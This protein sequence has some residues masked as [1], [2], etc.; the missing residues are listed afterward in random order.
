MRHAEEEH[1]LASTTEQNA[2]TR[3]PVVPDPGLEPAGAGAILAAGVAPLHYAP[4]MRIGR[5]R[6]VI[7]ALLFFA[8]TINYLDRMVLGILAPTLQTDIG[9]ND[10]QY[11]WISSAFTGAYAFGLVSMGWVMDRFGTRRGFSFSITLWSLAAMGHGLARSAWGFGAARFCLALGEGGNFP[12]AIKTVAEWFP[13]KER[14][15]ATGI[16]NAGANVGALLAPLLVPAIVVAFG[17]PWAFVLTGAAGFIWLAAWLAIYR[18]PEEHPR[19]SAAELAYIRSDPPE[20]TTKIPWA[21]LLPH[22]QTWAFAVGKFLT[23]PVWWVIGTFWA[24]KYLAD[25]YGLTLT[26]L[27]LPLV[28]IYPRRRRG[29]HRRRVGLLRAD[30]AR[31]ER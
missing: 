4:G 25:T 6:W 17:W 15:L 10:A 23:D 27:A 5:F 28:V 30:Q 24:A 11:G 19:L 7:C 14:A 26:G 29:Q 3:V 8:T 12:G 16:F 20:A 13:K 22:R 31:L 9:W 18:P 2:P 1:S 21:S